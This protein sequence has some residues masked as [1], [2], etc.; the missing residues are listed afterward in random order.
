MSIYTLKLILHT[1][2]CLVLMW[3]CFCRQARSTSTTR[4][5]IRMAFWLL[6]IASM[7]MAIAPWAY[8]L[9]PGSFARYR[10]TWPILLM[11]AS[12]AYVQIVTARHWHRGAPAAFQKKEPS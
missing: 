12:V 7:L 8:K 10:V 5:S 3:S 9:W 1:V 4:E 11:L 2:L 6:F